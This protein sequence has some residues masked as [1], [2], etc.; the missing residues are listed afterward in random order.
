MD[1][2]GMNDAFVRCYFNQKV[3]KETD[4]H[5]RNQDGKAS[6]NYRLLFPFTYPKK[7]KD[8]YA[9]TIQAFDKDFFNPDD[10]IGETRMNIEIPIEDVILTKRAITISKEYYNNFL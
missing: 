2:E 3:Y 8:D 1:D 9:L 10:L 4:I 5:F 6:F 7:T